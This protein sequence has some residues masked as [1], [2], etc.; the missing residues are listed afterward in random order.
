MATVTQI[1]D[2]DSC[3]T[4]QNYSK[5]SLDFARDDLKGVI[6]SDAKRSRTFSSEIPNAT[7]QRLIL[8]MLGF[9]LRRAV[10]I[11]E[12]NR[13]ARFFASLENDTA[14]RCSEGS[15]RDFAQNDA[16]EK[17][18]RLAWRDLLLRLFRQKKKRQWLSAHIC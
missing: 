12:R 6:L 2:L 18:P 5:G 10:V 1:K 7:T 15:R 4:I 14:G 17:A 8:A 3:S 11:L 13:P 9:R 16:E